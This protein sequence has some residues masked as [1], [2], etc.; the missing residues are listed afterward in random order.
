MSAKSHVVVVTDSSADLPL[1]WAQSA[2]VHVV[3]QIV[4]LGDDRF[5]DQTEISRAEVYRHLREG[6]PLHIA[7]P[8]PDDFRVLFRKMAP[9]VTGIVVVALS[10]FFNPTMV[11]AD[12]AAVTY[13]K[14]PAIAINTRSVSLG[15][16]FVA[17]ATAAY[18]GEGH[19]LDEVA[20]YAR[21]AA[22]YSHVVFLGGEWSRLLQH[23]HVPRA[24]VWRRL[25][26]QRALI[27]LEKGLP[28]LIG[29]GRGEK[30]YT[31]AMAFLEQRMRYPPSRVA[32]VHAAAEEEATRLK[33][34]V[35]K[36]W[37]LPSV[38]VV[39]LT[40][41]VALRMGVGTLGIAVL[42]QFPEAEAESPVEPWA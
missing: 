33:E 39:T 2:G 34:V 11:S 30:A 37:Q 21:R 32:V 13:K 6:R 35:Q 4:V 3:P 14:V 31:K 36:A 41:I 23:R 19:P 10:T 38:P 1:E 8:T 5:A 40:P 20:A 28:R 24:A 25:A 26:G 27:T 16:G 22:E 12:V 15:V 9:E 29:Y 42:E 18:A 17:L 7:H